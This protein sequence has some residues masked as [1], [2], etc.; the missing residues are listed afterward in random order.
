MEGDAMNAPLNHPLPLLD[1]DVLRTFVAIAETGSFTLAASA[2]FR[3]PSAVSMQIKKLEETL[4]RAVF[5]RDARSVSLTTDGEML[6]GYARRLLALNR[7]AVAKFVMP[8]ISGVVR[9]G[10]PDDFGERVL[11]VV[12]RRFAETHPSI[13]VDVVIDQSVNLR[14]RM[15]ERSLDI[16][17]LTNSTG[18][19]AADCEV[20][21]TEPI[22]WAGMKGGCAHLR[23]P[24]PVSLWEEGCAWRAGALEALGREGRNYRVAYMSAH[25]AGQR[26]AIL[27][28]LAIAPLPKSFIGHDLVEL[29]V[30]DGL[31]QMG[32]YNL[33]MIV[34]PDASAPV[35][36][37][38]D[39]IRAAFEAFKETGRF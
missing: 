1:L 12:L 22:V 24:L 28:D 2:V 19:Y 39:H 4:G 26:A 32:D 25:T 34:A 17:L 29:G 5:T 30:K 10:S 27:S 18:A 3:T 36:A 9:L 16:T 14:R 23:E 33:G 11:P 35:K 13:A 21:F 20:L 38:A 7:E 6:L 31:P 15:S 8:D 37:A